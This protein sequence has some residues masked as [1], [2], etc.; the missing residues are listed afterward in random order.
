VS[1]PGCTP[2]PWFVV[3]YTIYALNENG[4][5]RFSANV[6]ARF[7]KRG[8]QPDGVELGAN[9]HQMAASGVLYDALKKARDTINAFYVTIGMTEDGRAQNLAHIDAALALA[10][11]EKP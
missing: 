3:G 9:A 4:L 10:R 5:N 6:Q 8:T 1:A 11:G 7:S 2:G